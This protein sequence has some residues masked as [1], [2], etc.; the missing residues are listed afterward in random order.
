MIATEHVTQAV[1]VGSFDRISLQ[2]NNIENQVE[3]KHGQRESLTIEADSDVLA[4]LKVEVLD[5]QLAIRMGGSW[6]E[7]LSAALATSLT[8][9]Q[10]R[11]FVTARNLTGLEM[12]GL[13]HASVDGIETERL[14]VRFGGVGDLRI[15]GL[16]AGR[17]DIAVPAPSPCRIEVS[18]RA[19][20][21]HVT[22]HGMGEY[23]GR[24]LESRK[25][26]VGLKGPGG[27][28]VVRAEDELDVT[29]GG[30]GRVEYIGHPRV[31]R[32]IS[33]MGVLTHLS[34]NA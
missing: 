8:R 16:N 18:G 26:T 1:E 24:G 34:E 6:S 17:L 10:V 31:T 28:A 29:I 33:P 25:T 12:A 22:L 27:H 32:K 5:G 21:Q 30:P 4:R 19:H 14:D 2:V 20:E 7:K 15:A 11:Y 9:T 23:D 3:I 13:A